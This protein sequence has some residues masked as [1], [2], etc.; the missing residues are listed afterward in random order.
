MSAPHGKIQH[1][2]GYKCP[3]CGSPQ[4]RYMDFEHVGWSTKV[5][6]SC[7]ACDKEAVIAVTLI[8]DI[9]AYQVIS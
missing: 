2:I 3:H 1:K 5:V 9:K 4:S 6:D 7:D 8:P